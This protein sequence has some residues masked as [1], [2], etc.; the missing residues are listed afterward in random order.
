MA[1]LALPARRMPEARH[2]RSRGGRIELFLH[3]FPEMD[4]SFLVNSKLLTPERGLK[5]ADCS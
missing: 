3:Y 5:E 4:V 2:R 1:E